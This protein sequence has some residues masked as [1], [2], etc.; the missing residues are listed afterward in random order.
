MLEHGNY[1]FYAAGC[2]SCHTRD[3]PMAGGRPID[4]PFVTFYPLNVTPQ[5][6]YSIGAWTKKEFVHALREGI[7]P[8]GKDC[9]PA[10]PFPSYTGMT[11]QDMRTLYACL[12][13]LPKYSR[14]IRPRDLRW[15]FSSR[16]MISYWKEG[17][18][19]P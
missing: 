17:R 18:F 6:E 16:F 10:F 8:Q 12:M 5:K 19:V 14:K 2:I 11:K 3:Q 9:Y 7:G 13:M 1:V 4:T 15:P